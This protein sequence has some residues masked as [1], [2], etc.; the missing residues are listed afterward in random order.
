MARRCVA[1]LLDL[2]VFIFIFLIHSWHLSID[3]KTDCVN[4]QVWGGMHEIP[5]IKQISSKEVVLNARKCYP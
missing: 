3:Y 5:E 1:Q 4:A 2:T